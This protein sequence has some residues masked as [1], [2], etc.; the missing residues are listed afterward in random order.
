LQIEAVE[1]RE[2]CDEG[3]VATTAEATVEELAIVV[4]PLRWG[5]WQLVRGRA[6][7]G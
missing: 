7:P 2:D 4:I 6:M 1:D 5:W 3:V